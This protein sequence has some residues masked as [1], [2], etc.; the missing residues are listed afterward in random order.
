MSYKTPLIGIGTAALLLISP[1]CFA[2][3]VGNT[4]VSNQ[5]P[6]SYKQYAYRRGAAVNRT[7]VTRTTVEHTSVHRGAATPRVD[8][9]PVAR[10]TTRNSIYINNTTYNLYV[11]GRVRLA[12]G[13]HCYV[14]NYGYG[15]FYNGACLYRG[16]YYKT[17]Y[18]P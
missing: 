14:V 12:P 11:P 16:V 10:S 7:S 15:T 3:E 5:I 2:N 13:A 9:R 17:F 4:R 18:I 8:N 1:L 6:S